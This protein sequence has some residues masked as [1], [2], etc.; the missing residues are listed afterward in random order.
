MQ[1]RQQQQLFGCLT[2]GAVQSCHCGCC[3]QFL[4]CW[5]CLAFAADASALACPLE[6]LLPSMLRVRHEAQQQQQLLLR[7]QLRPGYNLH[8]CCELLRIWHH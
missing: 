3:W 6:L 2:Y 5:L 1:Q 8:A 7:A 4:C